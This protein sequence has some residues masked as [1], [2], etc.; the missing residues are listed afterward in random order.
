M[1]FGR[2]LLAAAALFAVGSFLAN[3]SLLAPPM[4]G[5]PT[6][7]AHRGLG[8]TFPSEGLESD[9]CTATRIRPPEHDFLENT[10][11]SMRAAFEAG[12]DVVELDIHPTADGHFVVFHDWTLECRTDGK[13][14][15]RETSLADLKKL[16]VGYGYTADG[17]LTFPFRGLGIGLMPSLDEVLSAFPDKRLLI[18]VKSRDAEEGRRLAAR[19][20][21]LSAD[22]RA[23]LAVYGHDVP[24][25]AVGAALPDLRTMS[26]SSLT[27]CMLTYVGVGWSSHVPDA[28]RHTIL[29]V[30]INYAWA[31]WG[32]PNRFLARMRDADTEVYLIGPYTGRNFTTG[33]DTAVEV[34]QL[35]AG[36]SGGI[37]TNRVQ[38][39]APL[40]A[41]KH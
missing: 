37:W 26:R 39:V 9:T 1:R 40:V 7:V 18:N 31:L 19:L 28:C 34:A 17:G 2:I 23:R 11:P 33:I 4:E 41:K 5:A 24:V 36:Y 38:A 25:D 35:P 14:V 3:T 30:P 10:I 20:G 13:G 27:R 32:W 12:A 16:D 21:T 8:Q 29:L 22:Q 6:L 15:T